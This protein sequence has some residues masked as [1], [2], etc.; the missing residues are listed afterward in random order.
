MLEHA[1]HSIGA[2]CFSENFTL[3]S[4]H[5]GR[6]S[7]KF[8]KLSLEID[9]ENLLHFNVNLSLLPTEKDYSPYVTYQL[10]DLSLGALYILRVY[11]DLSFSLEFN[12]YILNMVPLMPMVWKA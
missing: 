1:E 10:C 11:F 5:L 9:G 7:L 4:R 3:S 2:H 8:W 6:Y 12:P